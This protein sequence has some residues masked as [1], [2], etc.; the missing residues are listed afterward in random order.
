MDKILKANLKHLYQRRAMWFFWIIGGMFTVAI[1]GWIIT[2]KEQGAFALPALWMFVAGVLLS[3]PPLEVMTKPFSYCLPGH[4]TIPRKF[5]FTVNFMLGFLWSLV[6]L[7]YPDLSFSTGLFTVLGAFSLFTIA[8]WAGVLDRIYLRN[9]TVLLLAVLFVWLPLQELGAAVLYFTVVFPWML[10]SAGIFI[11]YLIWRH[12]QLADLP[13]RYCS[14]RQ[15]ELGIQAESKKNNVNEALKEEQASSYLKGICNDVDNFFL[16]RIRESIG[17]RRYLLGNIYRI[18]GPIFLK[19]RFKAWACLLWLIVVIYLGYMGPASSILFFMPVIMAASLNLGVH[20]GLLVCNG[21][22][23]RLWSALTGAVVFGLF[24]TFVLFLIAAFTK[25]LSPVM[26]TFNS[27]EEVYSFAPLDPRYC[28]MTLSLIPIGYIGQL[29][30]P[31]RQMLQMMPAIAVLIFGA[32]FFVPFA[33]DSFPLLG[34]TAVV[35]GGSWGVFVVV[36]RYVC[37]WRDL[38]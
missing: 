21:R 3:V 37:R 7:A 4:R 11:N 17:V 16:R 15:V 2:E 23:E 19:S 9:K 25:L 10:I 18:F 8:F 5:L 35:M 26:P 34:L 24:V 22:G 14:A 31:R 38:V 12:L 13:R 27:N 1:A 30:F 29:I 36:L 6:F 28:L 20:S 33:G 32:S